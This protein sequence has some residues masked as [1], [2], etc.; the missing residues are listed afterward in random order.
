MKKLSVLLLIFFAFALKAQYGTINALLDKLEERRGIGKNLKNISIDGSKFYLM[1]DF[2]DHSERY[3]VMLKDSKATYV[4]IFDDKTTGQS[5]S[6]VFSGDFI[7]SANQ[8]ISVR[9][10]HLEG[11]KIPMPIT[12]TFLLTQQKKILYL[13][14]INTKERWIH[15]R[16]ISQ[17]K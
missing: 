7:R 9:A 13:I 8:I 17:Q 15:E 5:S 3:F 10:D 12:K 1:K 6:N 16:S 14:D 11:R 4:E 2:P